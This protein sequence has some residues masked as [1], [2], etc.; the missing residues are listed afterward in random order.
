MAAGRFN[1]VWVQG[2]PFRKAFTARIGS[3][4]GPFRDLTG[5]G[6]RLQVRRRTSDPVPILDEATPESEFVTIDE[7]T[8]T[9]FVSFPAEFSLDPPAQR[10]VYG[11]NL[12]T[13][14]GDAVP[15]LE[16][17]WTIRPRPIR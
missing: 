15:F 11:I 14:E 1:L 10:G 3:A 4:T 12:V 16:G 17:N 8:A 9:V 2:T 5:F 6:A 13:P 7:E